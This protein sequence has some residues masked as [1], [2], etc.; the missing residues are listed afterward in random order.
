MKAKELYSQKH[1]FWAVS[2]SLMGTALAVLL[3]F[4]FPSDKPFYF[5]SESL[6][7]RVS[8]EYIEEMRA[9]NKVSLTYSPFSACPSLPIWLILLIFCFTISPVLILES[10]RAFRKLRHTFNYPIRRILWLLSILG[11]GMATLVFVPRLLSSQMNIHLYP[12]I[13]DFSTKLGISVLITTVASVLGLLVILITGNIAY[14]HRKRLPNKETIS[15]YYVL[16]QL[17]MRFLKIIGAL[18]S[19]ASLTTYFMQQ[20]H[21]DLYGKDQPFINS[22]G[23]ATEGIFY[24][25][26]LALFFIPARTELQR[27]GN[28]IVD[29]EL[30]K[31]PKEGESW[32]NWAAERES[33]LQTFG[34]KTS[35]KDLTGWAIPLLSP[36]I[37]SVLPEQFFR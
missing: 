7:A 27:F 11:A 28:Y 17:Q 33:M 8:P 14:N 2:L 19:L 23:V 24:T 32:Q 20:I 18:I 22:Q 37:S 5:D 10:T 16:H 4:Y 34:L 26:I 9:F 13:H 29:Q 3:Y 21:L 35:W 1:I 36:L 31:R 25:F 15:R 6:N 12:P 30:G